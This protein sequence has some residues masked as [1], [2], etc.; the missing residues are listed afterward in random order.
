MRRRTCV[1][2]GV[3]SDIAI[4][5]ALIQ[6]C[7]YIHIWTW[8]KPLP[9][10][11]LPTTSRLTGLNTS[12]K[13]NVTLRMCGQAT[14]TSDCDMP[15]SVARSRLQRPNWPE[16]QFRH[17]A[18]PASPLRGPPE[19]RPA[20]PHGICS[21]FPS[22]AGASRRHKSLQ[23]MYCSALPGPRPSGAGASRRHK[24]LQ[25]IYSAYI[26]LPFLNFAPQPGASTHMDV[27]RWR[28]VKMRRI[29][30]AFRPQICWTY[31]LARGGF[32][33]GSLVPFKI[34]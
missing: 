7:D 11:L 31:Q 23:A 29:R 24:S 8:C 2:R 5:C 19:L 6:C 32:H 21:K 12:S 14:N 15:T 16:P 30:V 28:R 33:R 3:R 13:S 9:L 10:R 20:H 22:G 1:W 25:A 18:R 34:S 27:F 17:F 26:H 4:T